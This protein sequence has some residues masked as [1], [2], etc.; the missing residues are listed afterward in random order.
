MT[1]QQKQVMDYIKAYGEITPF[2]AFGDLGITKLATRISELK[3]MGYRFEQEYVLATNRFGR[4]VHY[5]KY[6]FPEENN[7]D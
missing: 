2:E 5:M 7:N 1:T 4:P 6:K 3:Q